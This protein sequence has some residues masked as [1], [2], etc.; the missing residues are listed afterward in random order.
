MQVG[1][2]LLNGRLQI[3]HSLQT[4]LEETEERRQV[5]GG[6]ECKRTAH[7]GFISSSRRSSKFSTYLSTLLK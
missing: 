2:Q 1:G 5:S 3:V 7:F 4:V 6:Q